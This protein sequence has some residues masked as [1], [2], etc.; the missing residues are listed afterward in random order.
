MDWIG[1]LL[2]PAEQGNW[3][4]NL[5]DA[6]RDGADF[7]LCN[8]VGEACGSWALPWAL[9]YQNLYA[10]LI[11]GQRFQKLCL[12][13]DDGI[14]PIIQCISLAMSVEYETEIIHSSRIVQVRISTV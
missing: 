9:I 10:I 14:F 4:A 6:A 7:Q 11:E 12:S 5:N 1:I 2:K 3:I 8:S 13:L